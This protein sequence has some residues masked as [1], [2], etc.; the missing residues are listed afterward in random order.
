MDAAASEIFL[1]LV[2]RSNYADF[3]PQQGALFAWRRRNSIN[4]RRINL[5]ADVLYVADR[6]AAS[7]K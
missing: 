1:D 6:H 5:Q 4:R 3:L 2:K 7:A